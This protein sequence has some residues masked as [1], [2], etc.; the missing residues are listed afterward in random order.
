[1]SGY[2]ITPAALEDLDEIAIYIAK[3]NP[4]AADRVIDAIFAAFA[5]LADHP[6]L[7][8]ARDDLTPRKVKF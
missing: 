1:V 2:A 4:A 7:G 8:H 6:D 3:D 5:A